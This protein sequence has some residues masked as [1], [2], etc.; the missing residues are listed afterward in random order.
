LDSRSFANRAGFYMSEINA[1]HPFRDGNG[2]AQREFVRQLG[3]EAGFVLDWGAVTAGR[4]RAASVE[5][6]T[7]GN[8]TALAGVIGRCLK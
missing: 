7:T 1:I 6:F 4:M 8:S 5:S 3:L 2:R